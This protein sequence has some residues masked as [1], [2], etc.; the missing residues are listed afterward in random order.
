MRRTIVAILLLNAWTAAFAQDTARD[1]ATTGT[2]HWFESCDH[3]KN[4]GLIVKLDGEPIY[5]SKFPVCRNNGPTPTAQERKIVFHF[6]GGHVFQGEYRTSRTQTIEANIWQ[7]GADPDALLLGV[8]FVSDR[9][10]LNT[11]HIAK[12]DGTSV[13]QLD[14]GI[15]VKTFPLARK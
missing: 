9:V 12:S 13:S 1:S 14:S 10:L 3:S 15:V 11:S 8:T 4:L 6:K 2:W 5:R 7:A